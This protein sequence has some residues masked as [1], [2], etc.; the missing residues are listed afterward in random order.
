MKCLYYYNI[1]MLNMLTIIPSLQDPCKRFMFMKA[2][3]ST[4]KSFTNMY[5]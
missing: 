5:Y 3:L 2:A 1:K 4:V